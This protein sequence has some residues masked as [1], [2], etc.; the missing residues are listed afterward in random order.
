MNVTEVI[1]GQTFVH[2]T[3][4]TFIE[5]SSLHPDYIYEWVVTAVTV[6]IGPY[7]YIVSI[8]TPEDGECSN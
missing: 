6:G 4:N 1:T 5:I 3:T 7:T 8:R 2:L